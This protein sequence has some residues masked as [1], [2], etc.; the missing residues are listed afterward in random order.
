MK[1]LLCLAL[2]ASAVACAKSQSVDEPASDG[3]SPQAAVEATDP[4]PADVGDVAATVASRPTLPAT[5]EPKTAPTEPTYAI[6]GCAAPDTARTAPTRGTPEDKV[7][8]AYAV[9]A[10]AGGVVISHKVPHACCL[11]G[12]VETKVD[13]NVVTVTEKLTGKPCRCLCGSGIETIVPVAAGEYE[14]KLV[15]EQPNSTP[16]AVTSQKVT[17]N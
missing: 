11:K 1:K 15:L 6:K 4:A 9:T 14:V 17:V 3:A 12:E 8:E 2:L 5:I 16:R 10:I 7:S 13:G